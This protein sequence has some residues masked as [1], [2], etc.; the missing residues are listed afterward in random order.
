M[1]CPKCVGGWLPAI[2]GW[3][4]GSYITCRPCTY[5]GCVNGIIHCCEP[6]N[7]GLPKGESNE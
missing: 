1:N 7:D 4:D 5:P 2:E 6:E 3:R